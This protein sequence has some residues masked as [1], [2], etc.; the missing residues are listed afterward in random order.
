MD[1]Q[2]SRSSLILLIAL[3]VFSGVV[4][5]LMMYIAITGSPCSV[6]CHNGSK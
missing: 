1:Q 2:S 3:T 4:V 5:A 6:V